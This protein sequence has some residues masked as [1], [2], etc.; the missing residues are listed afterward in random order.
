MTNI[1]I[2]LTVGLLIALGAAVISIVVCM[3]MYSEVDKCCAETQALRH[4]YE[5]FKQN[6]EDNYTLMKDLHNL[7]DEV[8]EHDRQVIDE[9]TRILADMAKLQARL[10][11]MDDNS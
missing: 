2:I 9:N 8:L 4:V 6:N 3:R 11:D 1:D 5:D 7:I 10:E